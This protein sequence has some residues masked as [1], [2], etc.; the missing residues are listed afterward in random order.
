MW[1]RP[2]RAA[3]LLLVFGLSP[4]QAPSQT[5]DQIMEAHSDRSFLFGKVYEYDV[6][7]DVV[8]EN[9]PL[10]VLGKGV[11]SGWRRL[12][13]G[14]IVPET[15]TVPVRI[16]HFIESQEEPYLPEGEITVFWE[17]FS[18]GESRRFNRSLIGN[19]G[20]RIEH[21]CHV[22][23]GGI[24]SVISADPFIS[25]LFIGTTAT[26]R[27]GGEEFHP[28]RGKVSLGVTKEKLSG[29]GEVLKLFNEEQ[30]WEKTYSSGPEFYVVDDTLTG[31][32]V[33]SLRSI[34]GVRYPSA[35]RMTFG[36]Y[37]A[38]FSLRSVEPLPDDF[39][40]WFTDWP[41]GSVVVNAIDGS[42]TRI[43]YTEVESAKIRDFFAGDS[44]AAAIE[45]SRQRSLLIFLNLALVVGII[46]IVIFRKKFFHAGA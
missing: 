39:N 15:W 1:Y 14:H 27:F 41:N 11:L 43:P 17:A 4:S 31:L 22:S 34:N 19:G 8:A 20:N 12:T 37:D 46:A 16:E 40:G 35:G 10:D 32:R 28:T 18:E 26:N 7:Y 2:A 9:S 45:S 25:S 29:L 33:D 44:P 36:Y 21:E 23:A 42:V 5:A 24:F 38:S 6:D 30:T 13:I 3:L